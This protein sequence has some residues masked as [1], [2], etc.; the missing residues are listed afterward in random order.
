MF[1]KGNERTIYSK[2]IRA[3]FFLILEIGINLEIG[4]LE[5]GDWRFRCFTGVNS[6]SAHKQGKSKDCFLKNQYFLQEFLMTSV[7]KPIYYERSI[8]QLGCSP[9]GKYSLLCLK[10][11]LV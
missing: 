2:Y 6:G 8:T 7:I 3:F 9:V 4:W 5:R 11:G 1:Y 10:N